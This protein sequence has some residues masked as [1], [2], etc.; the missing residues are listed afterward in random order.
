MKLHVDAIMA[1]L[2][3]T[4]GIKREDKEEAEIAVNIYLVNYI[5]AEFS[6]ATIS[7]SHTLITTYLAH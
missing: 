3:G 1:E 5:I 2:N 6:I 7:Y 4:R